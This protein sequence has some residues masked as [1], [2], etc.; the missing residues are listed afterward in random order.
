MAWRK[1]VSNWS[2][3]SRASEQGTDV[4]AKYWKC[5]DQ[6]DPRWSGEWQGWHTEN[7]DKV[8]PCFPLKQADVQGPN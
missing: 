4:L 1:S 2:L 5:W 7:R 6:T 3:G 8:W